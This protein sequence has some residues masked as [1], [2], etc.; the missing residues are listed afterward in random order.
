[1][2]GHYFGE[3]ATLY[4]LRD[5]GWTIIDGRELA[6]NVGPVL[7]YC[8]DNIG[9]M[10]NE[11]NLGCWYGALVE[12]DGEQLCLFGFEDPAHV[13]MLNLKFLGG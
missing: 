12:H 3:W 8:R 7:A 9:P 1:M 10:Y 6:R 13:T 2:A 4:R 5:S 11:T